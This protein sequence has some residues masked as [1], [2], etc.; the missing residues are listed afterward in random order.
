MSPVAE[1]K[2]P[3]SRSLMFSM[4]RLC[5]ASKGSTLSFSKKSWISPEKSE[6]VIKASLPK[7][8][9]DWMRPTIF[10]EVPFLSSPASARIWSMFSVISLM[11]TERLEFAG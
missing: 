7:E 1:M 4:P 3:V 5:S 6:I 10:T 9:M 2:S 8:R 11:S